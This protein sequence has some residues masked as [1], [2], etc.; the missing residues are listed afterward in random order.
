M[1]ETK[2]AL[3]RSAPLVSHRQKSGFHMTRLIFIGWTAISNILTI[4]ADGEEKQ[5]SSYD[6]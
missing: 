3:I 1:M 5:P 4:S 2:K 6:S